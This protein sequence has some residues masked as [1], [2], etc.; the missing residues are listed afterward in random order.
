MSIREQKSNILNDAFFFTKAGYAR[1][2]FLYISILWLCS[3]SHGI[4]LCKGCAIYF[5]CL[6]TMEDA[7]GAQFKDGQKK[8]IYFSL[9]FDS[10]FCQSVNRLA[11]RLT[12]IKFLLYNISF[13][14]FCHILVEHF[15]TTIRKKKQSH[16]NLWICTHTCSLCMLLTLYIFGLS[17]WSSSNCAA[18]I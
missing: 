16:Q 3:E 4:E 1:D 7:L 5:L 10:Y 14:V 6:H 13:Y 12:W 2:C 17:I 11:I 15:I 9:A 8:F 18:P